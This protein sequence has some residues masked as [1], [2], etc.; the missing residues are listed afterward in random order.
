M[1]T[2]SLP[3]APRSFPSAPHQEV[4]RLSGSAP[5]L[6]PGLAKTV[7]IPRKTAGYFFPVRAHPRH[8][9]AVGTN[10]FRR[11]PEGGV[12][13]KYDLLARPERRVGAGREDAFDYLPIWSAGET[14][15]NPGRP[16]FFASRPLQ[17]EARR[18]RPGTA[19]RKDLPKNRNWC[20]ST[21]NATETGVIAE[22]RFPPRWEDGFLS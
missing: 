22:A 15:V 8:H 13:R 6:P 18:S 10:A 9:L 21:R 16:G 2:I 20:K 12:L 3:A 14:K 17:P 1:L 11:S 7:P 19:A 5:G 4:T